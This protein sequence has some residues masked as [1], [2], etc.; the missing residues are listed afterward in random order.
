MSDHKTEV[1]TDGE[2]INNY[3][4]DLRRN[5]ALEIEVTM[6]RWRKNALSE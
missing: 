3:W 5:D 6:G 4:N 1:R 2:E